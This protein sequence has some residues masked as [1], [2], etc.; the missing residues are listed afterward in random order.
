M[1]TIL[2]RNSL[3][4][5]L[6][7]GQKKQ[8]IVFVFFL[9]LTKLMRGLQHASSSLPVSEPGRNKLNILFVFFYVTNQTAV[10]PRVRTQQN[11]TEVRSAK[12]I[13]F[14]TY[15]K[16]VYVPNEAYSNLYNMKARATS[17]ANHPGARPVEFMN[18]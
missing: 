2:P 3:S 11:L 15:N 13:L 17:S 6:R 16:E 18:T 7:P 9:I 5:L 8:N 4:V 1:I 12:Q 10:R 14:S